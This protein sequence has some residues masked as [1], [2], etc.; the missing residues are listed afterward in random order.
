M[1][2]ALSE[3][4]AELAGT[5]RA[6][7]DKQDDAAEAW[8]T[9]CHQVGVPALAVPEEYDG[10]GATFFETAIVLEELGRAI[11]PTP[12]LATVIATEAILAGGTADAKARLSPAS[13]P[14]RSPPSPSATV[15]CSTR[16][17]P[18]SCSPS[19]TTTSSS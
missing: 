6:V 8:S 2:F 12:L 14:E 17:A 3:E 11:V 5:V 16:T 4:Q 9:L 19:T 13:L 10:A 7:L 15:R 1:E 18:R